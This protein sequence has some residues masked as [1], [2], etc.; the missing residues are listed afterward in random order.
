MDIEDRL[1]KL[2]KTLDDVIRILEKIQTDTNKMST[3]I[4]FVDNVYTRVK[5]PLHFICDRINYL[6]GDGYSNNIK[7]NSQILANDITAQD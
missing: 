3:H 1:T 5:Q 7:S 6:R 4:D 2:E